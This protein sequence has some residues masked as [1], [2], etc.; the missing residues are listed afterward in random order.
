MKK[1]EVIT[2]GSMLNSDQVAT[3]KGSIWGYL[4]ARTDWSIENTIAA[5]DS[6]VNNAQQALLV[7]ATYD[8]LIAKKK[9]TKT[10]VKTKK[11]ARK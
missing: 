2:V 8:G 11:N 3:V 9:V 4:V 7:M 6:I 1:T 5:A 10:P